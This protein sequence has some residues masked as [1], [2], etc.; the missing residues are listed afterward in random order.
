MLSHNLL[1]HP[2]ESQCL[3]PQPYKLIW[4]PDYIEST[5]HVFPASIVGDIGLVIAKVP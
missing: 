1:G 2:M 4:V 5:L 3:I